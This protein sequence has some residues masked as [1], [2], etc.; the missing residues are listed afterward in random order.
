MGFYRI[1]KDNQVKTRQDVM[2]IFSQMSDPLMPYYSAGR[3]RLKLGFTGQSCCNEAAWLEGFS[4]VFWGA[5]PF[6][7]A[8]GEHPI[9]EYLLEGLKNGT[10][11]EH[12]EYWGKAADCDQRLVEMAAI[13]YAIMLKPEFFWE[14]LTSE[15]QKNLYEWLNQINQVQVVDNNWNF[16][17]VLV[18]LAF[19]KVGLV[20]DSELMEETLSKIDGMYRSDGWFQ[21]GESGMFDYYNSLAFHFYTMVYYRERKDTDPERCERY[22]SYAIDFAAQFKMWF[23]GEGS[24][25][26][27]GRSQVYRFAQ[28]SSFVGAALAGV[29][30]IPWGECKW[31]VLNHLRHWLKTDMLDRDGVLSIGY[32]YP[33]LIMSDIYNSSGSPYWA[34]KIF[35]ILALDENHPFW[36]AEETKPSSENCVSVQRM[37]GF[38]VQRLD[39]GSHVVALSGKQGRGGTNG[40]CLSSYD[41]KY[42]KFAYSSRFGFSVSR[43]SYALGMGA[44]DSMLALRR[45]GEECFHVKTNQK[46]IKIC[47]DYIHSQWSPMEGVMI[48]TTL[49]PVRGGH[50]RYHR[51]QSNIALETAEGGFCVR[52]DE[53]NNTVRQGDDWIEIEDGVNISSIRDLSNIHRISRSIYPEP[54]T[55]LMVPRTL[56]PML[57]GEIPAGETWLICAVHGGDKSYYRTWNMEQDWINEVKNEKR[58]YI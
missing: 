8:G 55:N 58:S 38:L 47:E 54:N 36:Q 15:E 1:D 20:Y 50:L 3:A 5:G 39:G 16:F 57:C 44:F 34:F 49:V 21:D 14:R 51:I 13:A 52:L 23:S 42:G 53:K 25:I 43:N 41:S 29:E 22:R 2:R 48:D 6:V 11:P 40:Y 4:R 26:P 46:L 33:N 45:P 12:R 18:N 19:D 32:E 17:R 9:L 31:I 35:G 28:V 27:F 37:P 56:L 30:V 7:A 10:N 24:A